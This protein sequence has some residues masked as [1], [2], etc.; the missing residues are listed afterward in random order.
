MSFAG[1]NDEIATGDKGEYRFVVSD[2]FSICFL[3]FAGITMLR[4][5]NFSSAYGAFL[6]LTCAPDNLYRQPCLLLQ[7]SAI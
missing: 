1:G 6:S 2:W 3:I 5:N 7:Y 4:G